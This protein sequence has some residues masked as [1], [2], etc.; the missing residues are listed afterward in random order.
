VQKAA[1]S[2]T[3]Q[4][5]P[6]WS[7]VETLGRKDLRSRRFAAE[8]APRRRLSVEMRNEYLVGDL[9]YGV[10]DIV[11]TCMEVEK[12]FFRLTAA[13]DPSQV[14]PVRVLVQVAILQSKLLAASVIRGILGARDGKGEL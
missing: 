11:G 2:A 10:R 9:A 5:S 4:P 14:R 8:K 12:Q 6:N 7:V 13:P 3:I 1:L